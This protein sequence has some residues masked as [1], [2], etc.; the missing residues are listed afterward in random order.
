MIF[1][2]AKAW[3]IT[4]AED[5]LCSSAV[6]AI[7]NRTVRIGFSSE[8]RSAQKRAERGGL[9]ERRDRGLHEGDALEEHTES[10]DN[11]SDFLES[12]VLEEQVHHRAEEKDHGR[13]SAD[14]EGGDLCCH[15][16]SD[17]GAHDDADRLAQGHQAGCDEADDHNIRGRGT[18]HEDRDGNTC[19]N[20]SDLVLGRFSQNDLKIVAAGVLEAA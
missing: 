3:K 4:V 13:I 5:E 16:R 11:G 6:K 17:V 7:P 12:P 18:L 2:T 14:V 19:Q 20:R 15:G 1:C 9:C 8:V 10:E